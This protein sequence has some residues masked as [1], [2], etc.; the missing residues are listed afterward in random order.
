MN[1]IIE[2]IK[3]KN[4]RLIKSLGQNFLIDD[5]IIGKIIDS[6]DVRENDLVIEIGPGVGSLTEGLA[7][8]AKKVIAIEI[9]KNIIEPLKDNLKEYDNIEILNEDILKVSIV[10]II[11]S[12]RDKYSYNDVIVV[13]NL[14]Y[15]ITTA[16]IMKVLEKE[17]YVRRMVLMMQKEVAERIIAKP[18]KKDY[19]SLSIAVQFYTDA[20]KQFDVSPQCFIPKPDVKSTVVKLEILKDS[21]VD[22]LSKELFFKIVRDSFNQRRKTLVNALTNNKSTSLSKEEIKN[23]LTQIGVNEK[24]R[25]EA[26][27]IMQFAELSNLIYKKHDSK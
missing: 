20:T 2:T 7:Q 13:S 12:E 9:D 19:G 16:I 24:T 17:K 8:R 3:N 5:N 21:R 14:P 27:D 25:G 6:A 26:L 1:K 4:I 11:E 10:S 15:Y 22:I 23:I 18:G